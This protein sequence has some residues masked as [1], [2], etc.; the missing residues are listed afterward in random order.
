M[1]ATIK[2]R[3]KTG[4]VAG[5]R[6]KNLTARK[7]GKTTRTLE[8]SEPAPVTEMAIEVAWRPRYNSKAADEEG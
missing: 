8:K 3:K 4:A 6:K 1:K 2:K 5:A 7:T